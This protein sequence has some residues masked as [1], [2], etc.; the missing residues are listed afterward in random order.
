[1][2]ERKGSKK[3]RKKDRESEQPPATMEQKCPERANNRQPQWSKSALKGVIA[4]MWMAGV[5]SE[6]G[7][8]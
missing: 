5:E 4:T 1:M 3:C 8:D 6:R 2:H 7:N